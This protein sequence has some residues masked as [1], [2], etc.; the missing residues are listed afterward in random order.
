MSFLLVAG[1][2]VLLLVSGNFFHVLNLVSFAFM[3]I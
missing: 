2:V 3:G 1:C